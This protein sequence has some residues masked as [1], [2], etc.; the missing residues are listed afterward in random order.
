MVV[1]LS[2]LQ[3]EKV[4]EKAAE[5]TSDLENTSCEGRLKELGTQTEGKDF[6][7]QEDFFMPLNM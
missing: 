2:S 1:W 7:S 3:M 6:K 4:K 5:M